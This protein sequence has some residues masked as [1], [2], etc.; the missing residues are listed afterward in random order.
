MTGCFS[1]GFR[2][3]FCAY[4]AHPDQ[5]S[6]C[7]IEAG[8]GS[9]AHV[10][11]SPHRHCGKAAAP[12]VSRAGE[13]SAL[14]PGGQVRWPSRD[15][16][17]MCSISPPGG[18][19]V[20]FPSCSCRRAGRASEGSLPFAGSGVVAGELGGQV[21]LARIR[22]PASPCWCWRRSGRH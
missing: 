20:A 2:V 10:M 14:R 13:T 12:G 5:R 18:F 8:S 17:S 6:E 1:S 15:A 11:N 19:P 3:S 9:L 16:L 21:V 22:S 4:M 7:R